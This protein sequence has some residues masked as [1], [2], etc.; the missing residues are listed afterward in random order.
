MTKYECR[1]AANSP[2]RCVIECS[3]GI[4]PF[5]CCLTGASSCNWRRVGDQKP[6][7]P[8]WCKVGA[9]VWFSGAKDIGYEPGYL[10]I[11]DVGYNGMENVINAEGDGIISMPLSVVKEARL[12]PWTYKEAIGKTVFW[13]FDNS[14]KE[15]ASMI[16]RADDEGN[17]YVCG[18]GEL[19]AKKLMM[20]ERFSQS[21]GSPCGVLEHKN[22][23]GEWVE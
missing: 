22:E 10:K 3:P 17:V 8:K 16:V 14:K 15:I 2:C 19:K 11:T 6:E 4:A 18:Y 13:K 23:Q 20:E 21:D 9:W 5:R 12:R 7:L 1:C